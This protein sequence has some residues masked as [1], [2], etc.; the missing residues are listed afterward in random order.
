MNMHC[1]ESTTYYHLLIIINK[2]TY[3]PN[4]MTDYEW[5]IKSSIQ[6][7]LHQ[8][9]ECLE[10]RNRTINRQN[11]HT[12][13]CKHLG[14]NTVNGLETKEIHLYSIFLILDCPTQPTA[15]HSKPLLLTHHKPNNQKN[16]SGAYN[17][18]NFYKAHNTIC[19]SNDTYKDCKHN[20]LAIIK[21]VDLDLLASQ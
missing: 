14:F 7:T 6:T 16:D 20:K 10:Y 1:D 21:A 8:S 13:R 15:L 3:F 2:Q 18:L 9:E 12:F 11:L 4:T 19:Y 17:F 5:P